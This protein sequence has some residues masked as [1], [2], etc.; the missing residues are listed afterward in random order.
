MLLVIGQ[1]LQAGH[2]AYDNQ[3]YS[4]LSND[5][6]TNVS[7]A[8]E[9]IH[10]RLTC[11]NLVREIA[12]SCVHL[13]ER[14]CFHWQIPCYNFFLPHAVAL[15]HTRSRTFHRVV[16][17][18]GAAEPGRLEQRRSAFGLVDVVFLGLLGRR[19]DGVVPVGKCQLGID[20]LQ[21]ELERVGQERVRR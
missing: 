10:D 17:R 4:T 6:V 18:V 19:L 8:G 20:K 7:A 9:Y 16:V 12:G 3:V 5:A 11:T 2:V 21:A 14:D 15:K 13:Q 1:Y